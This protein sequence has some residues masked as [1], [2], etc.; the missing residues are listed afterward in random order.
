MLY[1]ALQF[2]LQT[3]MVSLKA[4]NDRLQQIVGKK[5][6]MTEKTQA[7]SPTNRNDQQQRLSLGD[8]AGLGE[9]KKSFVNYHLL[10]F[11]LV[12]ILNFITR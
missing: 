1:F 11:C 7:V 12:I 3:E 9:Q 10:S 8:P 4:N 6:L 5:G 2:V